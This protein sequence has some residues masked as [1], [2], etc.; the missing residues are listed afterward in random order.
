[1]PFILNYYHLNI[2]SADYIKEYLIS[3]RIIL[4]CKEYL[5][6]ALYN[7]ILAIEKLRQMLVR[8]M[9]EA[10]D[11][12]QYYSILLYTL[13]LYMDCVGSDTSYKE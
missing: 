3:F 1:M 9:R 5:T 8:L 6:P 2:G 7:S 13:N 12:V 4:A 10:A 11:K